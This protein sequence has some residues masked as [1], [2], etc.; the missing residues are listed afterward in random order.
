[1][2]VEN[3]KILVEFCASENHVQD[4]A[5][6]RLSIA[7]NCLFSGDGQGRLRRDQGKPVIDRLAALTAIKGRAVKP[8]DIFGAPRAAGGCTVD[9]FG[10]DIIADAMDHRIHL[11][12]LRMIVNAIANNSQLKQS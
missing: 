8:L 11:L 7:K 9:L 6:K 2:D 10:I 1:M 12:Q 5:C 4:F 3:M